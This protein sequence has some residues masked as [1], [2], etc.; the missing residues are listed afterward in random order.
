M[1]RHREDALKSSRVFAPRQYTWTLIRNSAAKD[2]QRHAAIASALLQENHPG[3]LSFFLVAGRSPLI[4]RLPRASRGA[5]CLAVFCSLLLRFFAPILCFQ[6]LTRKYCSTHRLGVPDQK[7]RRFLWCE[8][9]HSHRR[10]RPIRAK[11]GRRQSHLQD[12]NEARGHAGGN[13]ANAGTSSPSIARWR[14]RS[15]WS[16]TSRAATA[17]TIARRHPAAR[18]SGVDCDSR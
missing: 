10:A 1:N 3:A 7:N 12:P 13:C 9:L 18:P 5:T 2:P 17:A 15:T 8:A 16:A 4:T 6:R 14:A 11:A